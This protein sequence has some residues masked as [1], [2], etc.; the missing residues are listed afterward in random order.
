MEQ[1]FIISREVKFNLSFDFCIFKIK[2][3]TL[4]QINSEK[5]TYNED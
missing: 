1:I 4:P 3:V 5:R 2:R